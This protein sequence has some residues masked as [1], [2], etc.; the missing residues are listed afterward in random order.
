MDYLRAFD[1]TVHVHGSDTA[2]VTMDGDTYTYTEFDNRS[3]Q[4]ANALDERVGNSPCAVLAC[5]G[6]QAAESMIASHKRGSPT[7]QLPFRDE[8]AELV[9][10]A[11]TAGATALVFDDANATTAR[12]LFELG[13]FDAGIH[14][15]ERDL[16]VDW[17][18][19]Y[20]SVL[21]KASRDLPEH[22]PADGKTNVF[23]TSGTTTLPKAVR[24]DGEQMWIGAYQAVMEHGIDQTDVAGV[25]T[26][27]YHM[28]TSASWLYPHWAAG[29]TT[30]LQSQYDPDETL[31]LLE[32]HDATGLLAVPA[33]L[34]EL[35]KSQADANYDVDSLSYV[36]TGGAIVP[37]TL[38]DRVRNQLTEAV[39]N[40]YGM[41]E[42]GPNLTFAH[43]SVQD[44]HP[45]TIGKKS[46]SWELRVVEQ[47]GLDERPDPQATVDPGE[48]GEIIARGPGLPDG[49]VD[50]P[51]AEARN[52]F[53]GWLRTR[54]VAKVDSDGFLYIVDRVDNMFTSGGENI[55]P[56]E[57]ENALE[58]HED[59][60]E[61]LVVGLNDDHWGNKV[62]A[63]VVVDGPVG[64][65]KLDDFCRKHPSLADFKRPRE[66]ATRTE[67]LPRTETGTIERERVVEE[68]FG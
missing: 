15:G 66:Y 23:Y 3:T 6:L 17:A 30:V 67:P 31:S 32:R 18:E 34:D 53:D 46:F 11:E 47:V 25:I 5:N 8:P 20:E 24:F 62:A 1:R 19:S 43:P 40:T 13:D 4:L 61:A 52:F 42:A 41:T 27:W 9:Q 37:E 44:D 45:G 63:V 55:Y 56:T 57:V 16:G 2:I 10:M 36:R 64:P 59:V 38:I 54:D 35:C 22:L 68:H 51:K 39:Y 12:R 28:V 14:A 26:P 65:E 33:Q 50:N 49:Y 60:S 48:R 21:A 7:V 29:A 58:S